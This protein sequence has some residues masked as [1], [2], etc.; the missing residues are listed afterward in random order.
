[1]PPNEDGAIQWYK[2][3][4]EGSNKNPS[5]LPS[6]PLP[7]HPLQDDNKWDKDETGLGE[8]TIPPY[9]PSYPLPHYD[10]MDDDRFH[11]YHCDWMKYLSPCHSHRTMW[12][13]EE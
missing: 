8:K 9:P 12:Y 1:M 5:E 11:K 3:E 7:F 13:Y 4:N 6:I 10:I 2:N